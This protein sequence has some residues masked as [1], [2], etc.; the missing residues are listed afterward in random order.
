MPVCDRV[1]YVDSGSRD[2]SVAFARGFGVTVVELDTT[3][4]LP[5]PAPAMPGS[6][7][8]WRMGPGSVQ[9]VDGDCKVQPGWLEAGMVRWPNPTLGWRTGWRSEIRPQDSVYNQMCEV[10]W[11]RPGGPITACGGDMMVR[12]AAFSAQTGGF[13]PTVIAAEDD[14]ILPAPCP[15]RLEAGTPAGRND[16]P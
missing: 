9:F 12:V 16:P 3:T 1:V 7:R 6:R 8:C 14:G 11:H 10:E 15:G 4:P 5:P 13:D 2:D